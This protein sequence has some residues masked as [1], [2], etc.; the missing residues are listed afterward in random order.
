M[1]L[2][3]APSRAPADDF[4]FAPVPRT[5]GGAMVTEDNAIRLSTVYKCVRNIAETIG[6]LPLIVYE[7]RNRGKERAPD[8][9]LARLL[10]NPNPWQTAMQWRELMQGHASLYGNAYSEIVLDGAGREDALI[11]LHPQRTTVEVMDNGMPR[12][13][14]RDAKGRE[15]VLLA[16]EVL[17]LAGFSTDGYTGLNPVE[18]E[19]AA[20]GAAMTSRD[21][22][23]NYFGNA[24]R[25]PMWIKMPPGAKFASEEARQKFVDGF[26]Q[27][28]A[29]MNQGRV[30]VMDQGM[31]LQALSLS[32]SD[33][34]WLESRQ[35]SDVDICGLWRV[36]P[37]KVGIYDQAK[38]ANVE[39]AA[40]EWVTDCIAP[41]AR[42]WELALQRAL[43]FGDAYFPEHLLEGLLRGDTRTRFEAYG[44]GIQDGWLT[45]N[46]ARER[47]NLNA[48]DGLDDPLEPLNM[49]PAG[50]RGVDQVR[51]NP[52]G[53][54]A[55]G[56]APAITDARAVAILQASAERV[57]RKEAALLA[58]WA[59][60]TD[61]SA[62][63]LTEA[64]AGH[65]GF[66]ADV[67]AVTAD[68]ADAHVQQ[69]QAK[70]VGWLGARKSVADIETEQTAALMRLGA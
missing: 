58:R 2:S 59:R 17:H 60:H 54:A 49:A 43:D 4:W 46:E 62:A 52:P 32:P 38:W 56:A 20:I 41:W 12:Y 18:A 55:D 36:P 33:S 65:A 34:Q 68:A 23:A 14:T 64:L 25:P 63:A 5:G 50:S 6:S 48:I 8:H 37:H 51:G 35:Y 53:G 40:L 45:R 28:Y 10:A 21:F 39:Q 7:R 67:M 11:P 42:R 9:P 61:T 57:A 15:R 44:K 30:P 13:R 31:E 27:S 26:R 22:G 1:F 16:G 69:L 19:R 47:E 3:A 24:A 66:V 70:A 29:G